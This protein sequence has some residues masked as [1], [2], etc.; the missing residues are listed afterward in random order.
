M[1]GNMNTENQLFITFHLLKFD[2]KQTVQNRCLGKLACMCNRN[3][4][5]IIISMYMYVYGPCAWYK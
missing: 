3:Y 1:V 4:R 5:S 2:C